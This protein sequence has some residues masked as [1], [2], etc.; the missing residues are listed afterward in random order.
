MH[1]LTHKRF[2]FTL[3]NDYT[4]DRR[5]TRSS[6]SFNLYVSRIDT[7]KRRLYTCD[8]MTIVQSLSL[9]DRNSPAPFT[10]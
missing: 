8:L 4:Q 1:G 3:F 10:L 9:S 7:N 5:P 2:F 6:V